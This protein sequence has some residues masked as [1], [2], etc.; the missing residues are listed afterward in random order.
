MNPK[1]LAVGHTCLDMVH[2]VGSIPSP[3]EKV[4]SHSMALQIGGS[5]GNVARF[6]AILGG[7]ADV[8]AVVGKK[9]LP[10]TEALMS[11]LLDAGIGTELRHADCQCPNSTI[12]VL[13]NG[14]RL[15][16]SYQPNETL[17]LI[18]MP[19]NVS[20]YSMVLGDSYKLPMTRRAFAEADEN[21]MT[22]MLDV[23]KAIELDRLPAAD[24]VWLSQEAW[25]SIDDKHRDLRRLQDRFGGFV[26]VTNGAGPILWI[27]AQGDLG[28]HQPLKVKPINTLGA[29]DMFR[30]AFALGICMGNDV[31]RSVEVACKS[32]AEHITNTR[33]TKIVAGEHT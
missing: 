30:A 6:V 11:L 23:D 15:I 14:D 25:G 27:T 4:D 31:N 8:C 12:L 5:A 33:I 10:I 9:D 29:G 1:I 28:E 32:A 24:Y 20:G 17:D 16:S 13:P 7:S 3:D 22:T 2:H 21:M 26:G 18:H 19:D